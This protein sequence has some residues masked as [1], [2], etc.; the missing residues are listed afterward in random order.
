MKMA[1]K[2]EKENQANPNDIISAAVQY[3]LGILQKNHP[4]I[5]LEVINGNVDTGHLTDEV[6][7][8]YERFEAE[9]VPEEKREGILYEKVASYV[10]GGKVLKEEARKAVLSGGLEEKALS[11]NPFKRFSA[12]SELKG[13]IY[14]DDAIMAF[15]DIYSILKSGDYAQRMPKLA[16]AVQKVYDAS[17]FKPAMEFFNSHGLMT[18]DLYTKLKKS[19][20]KN[21]KEGVEDFS[22]GMQE[23]LLPQKQAVY[24]QATAIIVGLIG[25][26]MVFTSANMTG[27]VI[28]VLGSNWIKIFGAVL[29]FI[30]LIIFFN[31]KRE[32]KKINRGKKKS[33]TFKNR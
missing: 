17:F 13:E 11:W 2:S 33:K 26:L 32:T 14:L 15:K 22:T 21:V 7:R 30:A 24:Q 6:K 12:K 31:I 20:V 25:T 23:Y 4:T 9:G 1:K 29:F 8:I 10:A 18:K 28:G 3:G 5:P 19:V 16:E 27:G